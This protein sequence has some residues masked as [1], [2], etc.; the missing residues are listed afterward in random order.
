MDDIGSNLAE[1]RV[2]RRLYQDISGCLWNI[3][4]SVTWKLRVESSRLRSLNN[5]GSLQSR[6]RGR[7]TTWYEHSADLDRNNPCTDPVEPCRRPI[8][9]KGNAGYVVSHIRVASGRL[10]SM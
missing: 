7:D 3:A 8:H 5:G 10:L 2:Y 4:V 6:R 1:I 9:R